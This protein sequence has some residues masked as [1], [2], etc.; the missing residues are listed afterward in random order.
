MVTKNIGNAGAEPS[1][2]SFENAGAN[3]AEPGSGTDSQDGSIGEGMSSQ[4]IDDTE[5]V[6]A[7]D[8]EADTDGDDGGDSQQPSKL[9]RKLREGAEARRRLAEVETELG[10]LRQQAA[11][12]ETLLKHP[13][14]PEL[15]KQFRTG[16]G[17]TEAAT[18]E[19]DYEQMIPKDSFGF[20]PETK[21]GLDSYMKAAFKEMLGGLKRELQPVMREVGSVKTQREQA[22]WGDLTKQ[23]GEGISKWKAPAEKAARDYGIPLKRALAMVSDGEAMTMRAAK[24]AAASQAAARLP[25]MSDSRGRVG[26]AKNGRVMATSFADFLEKTKNNQRGT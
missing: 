20:D 12:F 14:G 26:A 17:T 4:V 9:Q 22:E 5:G 23:H 2:Q 3:D 7:D 11:A 10:T 13:N 16:N 1:G 21:Q 6:P 15:L 19:A 8:G 18:G 25:A 24:A